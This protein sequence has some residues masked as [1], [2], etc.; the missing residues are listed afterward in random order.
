V[1]SVVPLGIG[2]LQTVRDPGSRAQVCGVANII[3]LRSIASGNRGTAVESLSASRNLYPL[4][5]HYRRYS[6]RGPGHPISAHIADGV[7]QLKRHEF[8]DVRQGSRS[9]T[10]Y[11]EIF[12]KLA[13]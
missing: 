12:N 2:R 1:L 10:E 6:L 4:H 11:G 3:G 7:I 5:H 8:R 9:V 13:R